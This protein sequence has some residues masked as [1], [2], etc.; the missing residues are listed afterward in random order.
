MGGLPS[1]A[2]VWTSDRVAYDNFVYVINLLNAFDLDVPFIANGVMSFANGL[3][4][5]AG[6]ADCIGHPYIIATYANRTLDRT[7]SGD[8]LQ[9]VSIY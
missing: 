1:R 6:L 5:H 9:S 2:H 4:C 8:T 3:N 7:I